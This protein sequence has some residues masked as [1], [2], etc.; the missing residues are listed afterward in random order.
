[1]KYQKRKNTKKYN[2]YKHKYQKRKRP[3]RTR[4]YTIRRY[5]NNPKRKRRK[6]RNTLKRRKQGGTVLGPLLGILGGAGAASGI[7][8]ALQ[9]EDI[10]YGLKKE[11]MKRVKERTREINKRKTLR[12]NQIYF[13]DDDPRNKGD[14]NAKIQFNLVEKVPETT[15][16]AYEILDNG[17]ITVQQL[18]ELINTI[19]YTPEKV[20]SV[21]FDWDRTFS[22]T[23]GFGIDNGSGVLNYVNKQINFNVGVYTNKSSFLSLKRHYELYKIYNHHN[24]KQKIKLGE[25][26]IIGED[27]DGNQIM[28]KEHVSEWKHNPVNSPKQLAQTY[29]VPYA[30]RNKGDYDVN[31]MDNMERIKLLKELFTKA[32]AKGIYIFI[33]TNNKYSSTFLKEIMDTALDINFPLEHILRGG[34][35]T[36]SWMEG[37]TKYT[38]MTDGTHWPTV[39]IYKILGNERDWEGYMIPEYQYKI[40]YLTKKAKAFEL[41][42][43]DS[44][45]GSYVKGQGSYTEFLFDNITSIPNYDDDALDTTIDKKYSELFKK[46]LGEL[47]TQVM[48][49]SKRKSKMTKEIVERIKDQPPQK[50]P[51][52]LEP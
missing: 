30:V 37:M 39:N 14:P 38:V 20:N 21:V 47:K 31:N 43:K 48:G 32:Y 33:L 19:E 15:R 9:P 11:E 52:G 26:F 24:L 28:R 35:D 42:L 12:D 1:M 50:L 49:I 4:K 17:G 18:R 6:R 22:C 23:E 51:L 13:Y 3:T 10:H 34:L 27:E 41:K 2:T 25:E 40:D 7:Y 8:W 45:V 16:G 46:K 5:R 44:R 29:F 36:K